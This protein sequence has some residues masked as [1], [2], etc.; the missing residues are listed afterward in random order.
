[1]S[2][3]KRQNHH[4]KLSLLKAK[5]HYAIQVADLVSDLLQTDSSEH[6]CDLLSTQESCKLVANLHEVVDS[7]VGN[8][9][10]HQVCDLDS[11]MEFGLKHVVYVQ[12]LIWPS[13]N[14]NREDEFFEATTLA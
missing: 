1:M 14:N 13:T 5:F 2:T 7:Q 8:Q 9:V 12:S 10:C 11:V 4:G 3:V 6:V